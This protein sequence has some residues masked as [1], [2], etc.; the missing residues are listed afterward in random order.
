MRPKWWS[1]VKSA[2]TSHC[3]ISVMHTH[4]SRDDFL[5]EYPHLA[6]RIPGFPKDDYMEAIFKKLE[7]ALNYAE[8]HNLLPVILGD[9]FNWPRDNATRF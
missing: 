1:S 5:L 4:F 7:Y 3:N 6:S 2:G 9:L 8:E